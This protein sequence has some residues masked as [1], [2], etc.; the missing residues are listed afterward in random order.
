MLPIKNLRAWLDGKAVSLGIEPLDH[1]SWR[2]RVK[3]SP[4]RPTRLRLRGEV[5]LA[6]EALTHG[7][8]SWDGSNLCRHRDRQVSHGLILFGRPGLWTLVGLRDHR[9]IFSV[10]ELHGTSLTIELDLPARAEVEFDLCYAEDVEA[11]RLELQWAQWVADAMGRSDGPKMVGWCS[12]YYNYAWFTGDQLEEYVEEMAPLRERLG[13]DVFLVDA[14][15]FEHPGDWLTRER[16]RYPKTMK[17]YAQIISAAGFTPG[18][19]LG[20]FMVG[21]RSELFR[22]H[23]DWVC[24]DSAGAPI[25]MLHFVGENTMWFYRDRDWYILDTSHPGAMAYLSD[26]FSAFRRWGY[27]YF[28]TDFMF[29]GMV[30]EIDGRRIV[31]HTPG[32]TRTQYWREAAE[33]IRSAVGPDSFWSG[34]GC[35]LW[36]GIGLLDSNRLTGDIGPVWRP[37]HGWSLCAQTVINDYRLRNFVGPNLY[38]SDP[39][40]VMLRHWDHEWTDGEVTSMALLAG[41]GGGIFLTSDPL[42]ECLPERVGLYQFCA[43][44]AGD[45]GAQPLLRAEDNLAV[46]TRPGA[47]LLF[48]TGDTSLRR[49]VALGELGIEGEWHLWRWRVGPEGCADRLSVDLP[50]HHSALFFLRRKP[51]PRGYRPG[52]LAGE[53]VGIAGERGIFGRDLHTQ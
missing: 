33:T 40:C 13:M 37:A 25:P 52:S 12:W 21:D 18:I 27:R 11:E 1:A 47:V 14:N 8:H 51:F 23:P 49:E 44:A 10:F 24:R 41:M 28:K 45:R 5:A 6:K 50:P 19:W 36:A 17:R 7:W 3:A 29:W 39:D 22:D 26:V 9:E 2:L 32:K 43:R 46:V 30:D 53:N 35:P 15:H 42:H 38:Q 16:H 34:C 20:P 48:N 4:K 31:R